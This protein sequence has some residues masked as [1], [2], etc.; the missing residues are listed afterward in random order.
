MAQP[1]YCFNL[2]VLQVCQH[3]IL[4]E[5]HRALRHGSGVGPSICRHMWGSHCSSEMCTWYAGSSEAADILGTLYAT[6]Q[7]G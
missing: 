3:T 4:T 5:L 1:R 6:G 2:Y 7:Y